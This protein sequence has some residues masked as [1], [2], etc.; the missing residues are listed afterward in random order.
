LYFDTNKDTNIKYI[1]YRKTKGGN[2]TTSSSKDEEFS[3]EK[4]IVFML[5]GATFSE[6][7]SIYE[8]RESEKKD[9]LY[10][11]TNFIRPR[12]FLEELISL[13]EATPPS[14]TQQKR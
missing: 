5:G 4:M 14:S 2:T 12:V 1:Y 8:V 3:G 10:G 9:I 7:R 11:T 13:H 6:I